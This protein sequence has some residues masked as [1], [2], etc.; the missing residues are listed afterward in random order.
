MPTDTRLT[1]WCGFV[2]ALAWILATGSARAQ[3]MF[4][5][6]ELGKTVERNVGYARGWACDEPALVKG[7]IATRGDHNVWLVTGQR[8]GS[9]QCR[10][11]TDPYGVSYV[12]NVRVVPRAARGTPTLRRAATT[13]RTGTEM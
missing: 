3:E 9:T 11:G 6:L 8:A 10:V 5:V 1:R 4:L 12:F 2:V 13:S 7:E